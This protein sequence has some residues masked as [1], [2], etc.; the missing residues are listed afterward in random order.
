MLFD[1]EKNLRIDNTLK[2]T[3]NIS[4]DDESILKNLVKCFIS[5]GYKSYFD[6]A[7]NDDYEGRYALYYLINCLEND[8]RGNYFE[9]CIENIEKFENTYN[10]FISFLKQNKEYSE[11]AESWLQY[12]LFGET[13]E[14]DKITQMKNLYKLFLRKWKENGHKSN[15]EIV[16]IIREMIDIG[17]YKSIKRSYTPLYILTKSD[18]ISGDNVKMMEEIL[19]QIGE[20][21]YN[22][23]LLSVMTGNKKFHKFIPHIVDV[24]ISKNDIGTSLMEIIFDDGIIDVNSAK[25]LTNWIIKNKNTIDKDTKASVNFVKENHPE[26]Y[27]ELFGDKL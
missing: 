22:D 24:L 18:N 15:E 6:K 19:K 9:K 11:R 10:D 4:K 7:L 26:I 16:N 5:S 3:F 17:F 13:E 8:V 25:K 20:E 21:N 27:K 23:D 14:K 2:C 1:R 12:P